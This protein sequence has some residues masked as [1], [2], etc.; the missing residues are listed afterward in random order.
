MT[1]VLV[2]EDD[3][4]YSAQ[5]IRVLEG[6]GYSV[7]AAKDPEEALA[8]ID[9]YK[10]RAL[11]LDVLLAYNTALVLLHELRTYQDLSDIAIVVYTTRAD[12]FNEQTI[13]AYG[14]HTVLDKSTMHPNDTVKALR[15]AGVL[16]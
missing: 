5:Q 4:W 10:P 8:A 12:I 9:K 1:R 13:A 11:V 6:A 15:R 2:V 16:A 7:Y 3:P 14:I